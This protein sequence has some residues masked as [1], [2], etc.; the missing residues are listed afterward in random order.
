MYTDGVQVAVS[1]SSGLLGSALVPAL[2]SAGHEVRTL[3][4][5]PATRPDEVAWDPGGAS[6]DVTALAG[7]GAVV[8]LA[9][10][11][12]GQRWTDARRER[13]LRSR[14]DG[15]RLLAETVASLD[16]VPALLCASAIG[17]YGD[18]GDEPLTEA[19]SRGAGFLADVVEAWEGA[20]DPARAAGARVVHLRQGIVLA[21]RGGALARL[22]PPFRLGLGGRVG[23]G[24]QWWS[25]VALDDTVAAW[26]HAL[27]GE[28]EGAV[29]VTAPQ[30]VTNHDFV[31]AVGAALHRP[32][33]L[34]LPGFA[35]RAAFGQM[36]E[37]MLLG[38]QRVLPE[39]LERSGLA[40][41][42]PTLPQALAA[43]LR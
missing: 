27:T 35:V 8:H 24:R 30:P 28:L 3:V 26:L 11:S 41:A 43:A 22:L 6:I 7:V 18:R 29:N 39:R 10:E 4:R 2:R 9:G 13:I 19:S 34:P 25:W 14:V 36:G 20:A 15:T 1:G 32:T 37:E 42:H 12:I 23:T 17:F 31:K 16:P 38:G 21:R 5:R 40:F 33:V